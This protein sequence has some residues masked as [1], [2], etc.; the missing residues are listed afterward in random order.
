MVTVVYLP[1]TSLTVVIAAVVIAGV[2]FSRV[3]CVVLSN[4]A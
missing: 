1:F 2:V 3:V 4:V